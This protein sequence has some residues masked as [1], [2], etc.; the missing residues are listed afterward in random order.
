MFVTN[1]QRTVASHGIHYLRLY[2]NR[3]SSLCA[4]HINYQGLTVLFRHVELP[5]ALRLKVSGRGQHN[6][7]DE[8]KEE[9]A[10][11]RRCRSLILL[12]LLGNKTIFNVQYSVFDVLN[13]KHRIGNATASSGLSAMGYN[14]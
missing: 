11:R 9:Y 2:G 10:S 13:F 12:N 1:I 14:M 8:R 6:Y 3:K 5:L 7:L 4:C